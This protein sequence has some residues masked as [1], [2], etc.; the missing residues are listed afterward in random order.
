MSNESETKAF[1]TY[2]EAL[3]EFREAEA[4]LEGHFVLTSGLHSPAYLQAARV[5][6]DPRRGE[7]LCAALAKLVHEKLGSDPADVVV[8]PAMGGIIVGHEIGRQLGI[9]AMFVERK[10]GVFAL[11]RGFALTQGQRVLIVED[12]VTTATSS[13]ECIACVEAAGGTVVGEAALVDRSGGIADPGVAF[14]A[15]LRLSLPTYSSD[16][17]PLEL[18]RIPAV[19]PGSRPPT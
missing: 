3:N 19:K 2:D 12:V 13:R 7:R 9:S 11:R 17:I 6:M 10:E 18:S 5:M 8:S 15:L 1:M 14:V 4:Y 16:E